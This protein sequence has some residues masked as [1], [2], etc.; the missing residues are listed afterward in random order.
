ML[1]QLQSNPVIRLAVDLAFEFHRSS[2]CGWAA[3]ESS[4]SLW[5]SIFARAGD[6]SPIFVGF[7]ISRQVG[8]VVS[9]SLQAHQLK[10][11]LRLP[12]LWKQ[13]QKTNLSV[14]ITI[15]GAFIAEIS[16]ELGLWS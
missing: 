6:E 4:S 8:N 9:N 12:D 5:C 2:V 11:T 1:L 3:S 13:V 7:C 10:E 15:P 16:R 14:D